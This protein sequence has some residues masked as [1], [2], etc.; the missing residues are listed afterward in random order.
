MESI[1]KE[2]H[3]MKVQWNGGNKYQVSGS[4]GD[5]C[6]MDVMAKT[7]LC[8]KWELTGIPCKHVVVACWN[9]A[10]N[11]RATP[12]LESQ[13]K[14]EK[15]RSKHEDEPFM[16]DGKLSKKGRTMTCGNNAEASGSVSKQAQ[17]VE[18][19]VGQDGSGRSGVGV[20]IGL[21]V[22]DCAGGAGVGVGSQDGREM[23]DGIP[24]QSS[25]TGG[26]SEWSFL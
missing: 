18:P 26:A 22:A 12:P 15:K 8:R 11:D 1:K 24:T 9:M 14:E 20:V 4:F 6:V 2:A 13:T 19:V 3:L 23:G 7:C 25:A 5:Q 21:S 10:L 16:K 17:Q